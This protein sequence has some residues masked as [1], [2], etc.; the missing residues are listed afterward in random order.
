[1]GN[2]QFVRCVKPNQEK[3]PKKFTSGIALDQLKNA[4]LFE[5]IRIR[6]AGYLVRIDFKDFASRYKFCC[7]KQPE[8]IQENPK[9]ACESIIEQVRSERSAFDKNEVAMGKS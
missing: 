7:V 9:G 1:M 6:K 8:K 2:P 3:V 4:G 5:A